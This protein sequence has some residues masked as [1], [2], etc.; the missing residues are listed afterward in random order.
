MRRS[1][2]AANSAFM[3][4]GQFFGKGLLFVS[5][6][7]LSRHL[8]DKDFGSFLFLIVLGQV[9]LFVADMGVSLILNSRSSL[10]PEDTQDLFS[11]S[12]SLRI[13]F[14]ASGF[15]L[16]ILSGVLL[17]MTSD[18]LAVLA[19]IGLSVAFEAFAELFYSVFRSR[20]KMEFESV[21]RIL[22]GL[23]GL[24]CILLAIHFN[25]GLLVIALTFVFRAFVAMIVAFVNLKKVNIS[26]VPILDTSKLRELLLAALPLGI[27]GLVTILHLRA[28]NVVIRQIMGESAVA[29]WQECLRLVELLILL[30]APTLLPGA[31]FPALC[32]SFRDGAYREKVESMARVFT[33]MAVAFTLP[34]WS[35]GTAFLRLV[36]GN[37]YLRGIDHGD[38]QLCLYFALSGLLIVYLMHILLASLLAVNRV[39]VVIPVTGAA[40]L[41]VVV[42]NWLLLPELGIT[43]AGMMF[44]AG[45]LFIVISY[46][47]FL[48]KRGYHISI[49][50]PVLLSLLPVVPAASA[51]FIISNSHMALRLLLPTAIYVPLWIVTGGW[52]AVRTV[53]PFISES[54][55]SWS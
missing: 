18:R 20:E 53:F 15:P 36:W 27:M 54:A 49:W 10:R 5:M 23:S 34:V 21:S 31:L 6:M 55:H 33:C 2:Q 22:K 44:L 25:A 45:N 17:G 29:A 43:S 46:W 8:P 41:L 39:K 32:R 3:L 19:V 48:R 4:T 50:K 13:I 30:V 35:T 38:I 37:D 11:S 1:S 26:A 28:D 9:Y 47:I 51:A 7:L 40:L 24:I 16:L 42:S 14:A 52:R 12:F